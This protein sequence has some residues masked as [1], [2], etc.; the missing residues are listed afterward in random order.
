MFSITGEL[1]N[2]FECEAVSIYAV[3][4]NKRQIYTRNIKSN[5]VD[6]IRV[7]LSVE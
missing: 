5:R 7:D 3:D 2:L 6:E 1:K 4:L